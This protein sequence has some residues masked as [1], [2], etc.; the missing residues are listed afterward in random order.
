MTAFTEVAAG[1]VV[2]RYPYLDVNATLLVGDGEALLVD[3]LSTAAQAAELAAAARAVTSYRWSN[4]NT[5]HHYDHCFG[6]ATLSTGGPVWGH[7]AA[8]AELRQHATKIQRRLYEETA[9]ADP[10]M[11]AALADV[12]VLPPDH[13]V[14]AEATLSVGGRTVRLIHHGRGHTAGDLVVTVPDADV[15][16]AGDLIEQGGPP[17]FDDSY[18]LDWPATVA[19][20]LQHHIGAS[21][22]VVPGHGA[23]VGRAFVEAQHAD[24]TA[25]EW[26]IRD[27]HAD[28]AP[29][30]AITAKSPFPPEATAHAARRGFAQLA[31][32]T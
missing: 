21:T 12:D 18:P 11:A 7:E 31:G 27:A 23:P 14:H 1:V 24:L 28:G 20:L 32:R 4:V 19:E 16:L 10:E 3:T 29:P 8:A 9:A 6:N 13:T 15:V 22:V 2:L 30:E 26:L 25:L 17:G 5:H